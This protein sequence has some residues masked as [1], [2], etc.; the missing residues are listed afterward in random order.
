MLAELLDQHSIRLRSLHAG[1]TEHTQCPACE[2]GRTREKSL[3]VTI[4]ADGE[5]ATWTC[6][7]ATCASSPGGV[8]VHADRA[9]R[10]DRRPY[11]RPVMHSDTQRANRPEWLYDVFAERKI[12]ARVVETLGIYAT[13][14]DFGHPFG[15][16][17]TIVFPYRLNGE[18]V[19]RKYRSHPKQAM[20]QERDAL[21]TLFNVD[22]LG[23]TPSEVIIVEG[24]MDV[25][26]IMECGV[27]HVVSLKDGAPQAVRPETDP[28]AKRFLGLGT[29][30][31]ILAKAT[32][33]VLAGDMDAPGL[34][35]REELARRLGRHRCWLV[36][37]P[38]GHK[39]AG[40]V[41]R[42]LG[43]D[44]VLAALNDA[45]PYPIEGIQALKVGSLLALRAL[46]APTLLSTGCS[47]TDQIIK[48]PAE[49]RLIVV[50][51][52]PGHG[53]T[54]W[55]RFVMVHTMTRHDRRW[56]VFTP[57]M[58][59]WE[60]FVA[61]CAE[62]KVR[63]PFY[64][65]PGLTSMSQDEILD[66]ERWFASRLVMLVCDAETDAPTV[67]WL[68]EHATIAVLRHGVTDFLVDPWNEV[69]QTRAPGVTE[70]DHIGR[71][72]QRLKA[73]ALR[74]GVNVW[75]VAHPAKPQPK[76]GDAK[77]AVAPGP[78]D[79][80][81]SAHWFNRSDVGLTVHS[82]EPGKANVHLWKARYRRFGQRGAVATLDF[83]Q[84]LGLYST[85][86]AELLDDAPPSHW[87][88]FDR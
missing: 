21:P 7:R 22:A 27:N 61:E 26:A 70:T 24:E 2:G 80:S 46:P 42:E 28:Q 66:V 32:R 73:F 81:G 5:G 19:N 16:M 8:R 20:A 63:R 43:P 71:S 47:A 45:T 76:P 15:K 11:Q 64:P 54:N 3:A 60:Q 48:L 13:E 33:V 50:T 41:L 34:A 9:P 35:M 30:A 68:I 44:E 52:Y 6:H 17:P 55:T 1:Y 83:D 38:D 88:D 12:G 79:I 74:H 10:V 78:Y 57:E 65:K 86:A 37:W 36:T 18:T 62:V 75:V 84:A 58:Q 77:G 51:G 39:D 59:P 87:Q 4:D 23:S 56:V 14:R 40:D 49:G 25:A 67:D 85:P 72:L 53:K 82:P 29:H 31:E 69:D